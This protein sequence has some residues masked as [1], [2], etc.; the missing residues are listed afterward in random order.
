VDLFRYKL[1]RA[2]GDSYAIERFL[3]DNELVY[4]PISDAEK[5]SILEGLVDMGST[6][7][8]VLGQNYYKVRLFDRLTLF[9]TFLLIEV[10]LFLI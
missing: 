6:S 8:Q 7:T 10:W 4:T 3:K 1:H 2:A 9:K 5:Q